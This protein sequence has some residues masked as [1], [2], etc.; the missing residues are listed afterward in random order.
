MPSSSSDANA[1]ASACP[2]SMPPC[3]IVSRRRSSWRASL[4]LTVKPRG[5]RSSCS[6]SAR[7]R[8]AGDRRLDRL[9]RARRRHRLR[10]RRRRLGDRRAQP[11][12]RLAENRDELVAHPIGLLGGED[13]LLDQTGRVP[14]AHG[15]LRLDPLRHERLRVGGLVLL[16]VAVAA[17][18]DEIDDEVVAELRAIGQREPHGAQ[19]GLGIVGVDVDDR[20][21]EALREVARV[22]RRAAL[23][24]ARREADL[25]VRDQVQRAPGG[26]ALQALQVEGLGDHAL[27]REGSVAVD[28][29]REGDRRIVE[30]GAARAVGLLGTRP[31]LDDGVDRLEVARI[32]GDGD[33]DLPGGGEPRP[34]RRKVVLD[35]AAS[36]LGVDDQRVVGP[37]A[38]ELPEDRLVGPADRVDERVEPAAVG[39]P[40]HDLVR[41]GLG[42]ELDRLVEH[43]DEHVHPLERELLLPEERAPDVLLEPLHLRQAPEEADA[44]LG[45]EVDAKAARLDRLAEPDALG[46]VGDVLDLVRTRARVDLAEAR[47]RL[48]QRV[49][50]HGEPEQARGYPGLDIGGQRRNEAGLVQ[51]GV[52]HRLRAERIEPRREVAVH[53]VGLDERHR[54]SDRA[55]QGPCRPSRLPAPPRRASRRRLPTARR[56]R[57]PVPWSRPRSPA[58][59]AVRPQPCPRVSVS[60]RRPR[61]C[62]ATRAGRSRERRGSPRGAGRRTRRSARSG[63]VNPSHVL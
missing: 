11:V 30:P 31:A 32:G 59:R 49:A 2:Q 8:S 37:L 5:T 39:H 63:R 43:R 47:E 46:V 60:R 62:G 51:R 42:P 52:A 24:R 21:V 3:S 38:L 4:G 48:E 50:R 27:A 26:V 20:D 34:R 40:D 25:V 7:S 45:L 58:G 18:A 22:A 9:A 41:T 17:V 53:P 16:V 10:R 44:P 56:G 6:F 36:S 57:S 13:L 14:R 19:G 35:V 61:R 12:V 1:S 23:G 54:G 33:L 55:Q 28:Q 29:H 15:R